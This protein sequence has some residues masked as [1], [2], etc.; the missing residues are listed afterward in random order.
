MSES[1]SPT[2]TAAA[3]T[4]TKQPRATSLH[5]AAAVVRDQPLFAVEQFSVAGDC[6]TING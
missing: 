2:V 1:A 6:D 4:T 3:P 5:P